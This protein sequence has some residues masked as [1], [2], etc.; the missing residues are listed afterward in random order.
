M[1]PARVS[2]AIEFATWGEDASELLGVKV[3]KRARA[4]A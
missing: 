4:A 1:I 3:A 2:W